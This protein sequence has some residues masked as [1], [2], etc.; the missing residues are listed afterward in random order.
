MRGV[1]GVPSVLVAGIALVALAMA[2]WPGSEGADQVA[3]VRAMLFYNPIV[4]VYLAY[5]ATAGFIGILLWPAIAG[6][7]I[8]GVLLYIAWRN[9]RMPVE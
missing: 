9:G 6:H 4:A 7:C 8:V 5:L 2:C 3:P 1:S